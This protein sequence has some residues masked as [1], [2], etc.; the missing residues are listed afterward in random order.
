MA[1][2]RGLR[3]AGDRLVQSVQF[4]YIARPDW[5]TL[6]V[7][8]DKLLDNARVE[9][10]AKALWESYSTLAQRVRVGRDGIAYRPPDVF[11]W[12][13]ELTDLIRFRL[14][15]PTPWEGYAREHISS[16]WP[17]VTITPD[18]TTWPDHDLAAAYLQQKRHPFASLQIHSQG[19]APVDGLCLAA[20]D[21]RDGESAIVQ[22]LFTPEADSWTIPAT[23]AYELARR[24]EFVPH[25]H[26]D[27]R[28]LL[29]EGGY[30]AA[31]FL[32][33]WIRDPLAS[34]LTGDWQ[35]TKLERAHR[36]PGQAVLSHH[37]REKLGK[38]AF[39]A[40]VRLLVSSPDPRRRETIL[41]SLAVAFR[42][43][44]GD[45]ELERVD[46][47][48]AKLRGF[49]GQM[50]GRILPLD[51]LILSTAEL[52]CL[53]RLPPANLQTIRVDSLAFRE[54]GP[55][56]P[57][58]RGGIALGT[59]THRG[60]HIEVSWPTDNR[61]EL[62]LPR[63][64][65]GGMGSGKT[66]YGASFAL[67]AAAQGYS[68]FAFDVADGRLC[69]LIRDGIDD[70]GRLRI[71]DLGLT[72]WPIGLDWHESARGVDAMNRLSAECASYFSRFAD[73]TG[74][75]TR[76]WLRAAAKAVYGRP[77]AT[78]LEVVLMLV[79][80]VYRAQIVPG[81][82]D[83]ILREM[84]EQFD[85][86]SDGERRQ[87]VQPVLN[88]LDYLLDDDALKHILCMPSRPE[89]DWR[90]WADDGSIVLVRVPKNRL[91]DMAT[92][93]LMSFLIRKLWL[94][95]LTRQDQPLTAR[96]PCFVLMDEPHQYMS[97][98]AQLWE[99]MVVEARQWRLG[100]VWM[101]HSFGGQ[102]PTNLRRIIEAAGPHYLLLSSGK[103]TYEELAQE[104]AP[105]TVEEALRTPAYWGICRARA[106]GSVVE[107]FLVRLPPE[108]RRLA[109][110]SGLN[111][112]HA[113]RFGYH[114]V[115]VEKAILT[116]ERVI[117]QAMMGGRKRGRDQG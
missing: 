50:R 100:L 45:N 49:L 86:M 46:V 82:A 99:Q 95:I 31:C 22:V 101:F 84:W 5:V 73:E 39:K 62:C 12:E 115:E 51:C 96:R 74:G 97:G 40:C 17:H 116:R 90:R 44:A 48:P 92:D 1:A 57:L 52:G 14:A 103:E 83:P 10:L 72:D 110:R 61:D 70:S 113:K 25:L 11:A 16:C 89:I 102:F 38:S 71:I 42:G 91:G 37:T 58:R 34:L 67:S 35:E 98:S 65:I 81:L 112:E 55:A 33:E 41:R 75:R 105:Y 24:G 9:Q 27:A 20:Q 21:I 60:Q 114:R 68:V 87:F 13:I 107:P 59:V 53:L 18:E 85:Q 26:L 66:T 4:V 108:P 117:Y 7:T 3:V 69:D 19:L 93:A 94:A 32:A 30:R 56:E 23:E 76:R 111:L 6:R 47:P 80:P 78:L 15:V 54:I 88:R 79:S 109:D 63:V 43:L 77:G 36:L 106:V 8:P 104:I 29:R 64:I 28:D 2:V